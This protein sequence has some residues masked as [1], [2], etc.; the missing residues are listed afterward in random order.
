MKKLFPVSFFYILFFFITAFTHGVMQEFDKVAFYQLMEN[1]S[2]EAIDQEIRK[3]G[4]IPGINKD[5]YVGG[6]LMKK[7]G[8]IKGAMKKLN[9]FK[10]G[11]EKLEAA[12]GREKQNA[13]WRFLR[14]MIQEHAPKILNY[15]DNIKED[16]A[17]IQAN[18]KQ[19]P[20][21]VQSAV[22]NYRKQPGVLQTLKF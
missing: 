7:A 14:L 9:V 17:M 10:D 8:I 18:F 15:R 5:A 16:A 13:E 21:E 6:L 12:I 22:L 2:R 11:H 19:L 3:I 20:P 1:G 4:A